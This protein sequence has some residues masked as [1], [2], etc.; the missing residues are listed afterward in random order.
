MRASMRRYFRPMDSASLPRFARTKIQPPR[1][2][3]ATLVARPVLEP[4]LRDALLS[5]R[6]VLVW[7]AAGY[8]KT[9]ALARQVETLP[10]GTAAAWITA[11]EGD[12][13]HRLLDC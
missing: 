13:L 7:A 5:Q 9:A 1:L 6:L 2:R 3:A 10:A 8:G 11:D 4:R 12:D